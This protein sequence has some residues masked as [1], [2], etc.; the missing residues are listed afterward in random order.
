[1]YAFVRN[2]ITAMRC[3]M[4]LPNFHNKTVTLLGAGVSNMP[5]AGY[6]A[7]CATYIIEVLLF[8]PPFMGL[9]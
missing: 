1:M 9:P 7:G 4:S 5:L 6:L 3:A 8:E 2:P